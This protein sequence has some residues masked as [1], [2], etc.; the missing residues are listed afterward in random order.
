M[1]AP[2]GLQVS[3]SGIAAAVARLGRMPALADTVGRRALISAARDGKRMMFTEIL[4]QPQRRDPFWGATGTGSPFGL[5]IRTG[6]T[7]QRIT[8]GEQAYVAGDGTLYA[9]I[10]SPDGYMKTL[11]EGGT[12]TG[13]FAIPTAAA[14]T[15]AGA[16]RWPGGGPPGSFVWPTPRMKNFAH[17]QP[18]N[19]WLVIAG[20]KSPKARDLAQRGRRHAE[21]A[22]GPLGA[23]PGRLVFLKLFKDKV[24]YRPH[25][26][27][28]ALR[29]LMVPRMQEAGTQIGTEIV[30]GA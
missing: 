22:Q 19:R 29:R 24:T 17:G 18:K 21:M 2:L 16:D 28:A 14:Q 6:K 7:R 5:G 30:R 11:E 15:P 12:V 27:F 8:G 13:H 1:S 25:G 23:T 4:R 9:F 10:A 26:S 20:P 3:V